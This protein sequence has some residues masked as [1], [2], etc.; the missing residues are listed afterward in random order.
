MWSISL[1]INHKWFVETP[2]PCFVKLTYF[3]NSINPIWLYN[4]IDP[5]FA[6]W[7]GVRLLFQVNQNTRGS[8]EP[9]VRWVP[10]RRPQGG[11]RG[12]LRRRAR[13]DLPGGYGFLGYN[14]ISIRMWSLL[15]NYIYYNYTSMGIS[16][17]YRYY[18]FGF[19]CAY[20]FGYDSIYGCYNR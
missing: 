16:F 6:W 3:Y 1:Y 19:R 5:L 13:T 10:G 2:T 17:E 9:G 15:Y 14:V 7:F 11:R 4:Y 20:L 18:I 8:R 12:V